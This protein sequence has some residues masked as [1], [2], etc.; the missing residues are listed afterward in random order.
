[1]FV[2][3]KEGEDFVAAGGQPADTACHRELVGREP[4][5]QR[6][7]QLGAVPSARLEE[8]QQVAP[9]QP[10]LPAALVPHLVS[11]GRG[12]VVEDGDRRP[13]RWRT[14]GIGHGD[15]RAAGIIDRGEQLEDAATADGRR[16]A[17]H[18]SDLVTDG[19]RGE[20]GGARLGAGEARHGGFGA[21]QPAVGDGGTQIGEQHVRRVDPHRLGK[22]TQHTPTGRYG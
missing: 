21:G 16:A 17:Q 11:D 4:V 7:R 15:Q 20:R 5:Q 22:L 6:R 19:I 8:L 1:M 9:V 14:P 10:R 3:R 12:T 2:L 18:L 13:Y